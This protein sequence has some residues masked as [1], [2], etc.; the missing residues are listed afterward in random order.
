MK[1]TDYVYMVGSG[2]LGDNQTNDY[3]CNIYLVDSGDGFILIDSGAG[4][5][6]KAILEE[7]IKDGLDP[8][9]I[10]YIIITHGHADHS[11]GA[12]HLQKMTGAMVICSILTAPILET[13]DEDVISLTAAKRQG[14]YPENY[15]YHGCI[16][17]KFIKHG[18]L[19]IIGNLTFEVIET[20]G[21]SF[22]MIS[23]Y[24]PEL[25][26]MFCSDVVFDGG[27]IAKLNTP[28]FSLRELSKSI[29]ILA[30]YKVEG[31]YP[32]HFSPILH[33]GHEAIDIAN[34]YFENKQEPP[35]IV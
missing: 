35:S 2:A 19:F 16:P 11:G 1:L 10:D 15:Q 22:D 29:K 4:I 8:D 14:I 31:L 6:P 24:I 13:A 9:K 25:K 5:R 34:A 12:Y 30:N 3:D 33:H 21:H 17:G 32:G 7:A 26:S 23:C 28:D 18:E 27:K 20:P